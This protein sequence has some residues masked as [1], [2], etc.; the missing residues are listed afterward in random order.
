MTSASAE[1]E[2]SSCEDFDEDGRIPFRIERHH[3]IRR[4]EIH[5]EDVCDQAGGGERDRASVFGLA[6]PPQRKRDPTEHGE[7]D[8]RSRNEERCVEILRLVIIAGGFPAKAVRPRVDLMQTQ[9]H[10]DE[11]DGHERKRSETPRPPNC[12]PPVPIV[13]R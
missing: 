3:P 5:A 6:S 12:E 7:V 11:Q 4:G 13:R 9:E 10:W 8:D 1:Q 2:L